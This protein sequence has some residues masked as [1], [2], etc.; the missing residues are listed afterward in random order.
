MTAHFLTGPSRLRIHPALFSFAASALALATGAACGQAYP[1]KPVRVVTSAPGGGSD[2]VS[3]LLAQGL[4]ASLGQQVV[5]ENRGGGIVA[6]ETVAKSPADGYTLLYYGSALW[7]LPLMRKDVPYEPLRDFAPISWVSRQP[8]VLV[9]H[10]SLPA[11]SVKALIAL[12]RAQP[13]ALNYSSGGVGS[14]GHMGAELF[15]YLAGVDIVRIN[16]KGQGP[17]TND[18]VSG[19]VQ[20]TFGTS[21]SVMPHVKSGRLRALAVTS[22]EPSALAPGL[23][24]IAASGVPGYVSDQMSG[25]F[26]PS[27]TPAAVLAVLGQ[28]TVR[29]LNRQE[30]KD[31]VFQSGAEIVA[32]SPEQFAARI[33]EELARMGKLIKAVGIRDE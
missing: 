25:L 21:A 23:P 14:S 18:V 16:Y 19:Q 13:G 15:K 12:A 32:S 24:T 33:R 9:V 11:P 5:V 7:L 31:R 27:K 29:A 10:P 20:L 8:N 22:A 17:A 3:R 2:M 6:G 28:E 26:A 4:T 1:S 30:I